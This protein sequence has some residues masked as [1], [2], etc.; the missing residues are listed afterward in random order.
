VIV[1]E[2]G[3]MGIDHSLTTVA[4]FHQEPPMKRRRFNQQLTIGAISS[5]LPLMARYQQA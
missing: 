1:N 4:F 2:F 3:E 5:M